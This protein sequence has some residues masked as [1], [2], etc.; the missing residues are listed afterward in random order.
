MLRTAF[1]TINAEE[2]TDSYEEFYQEEDYKAPHFIRKHI[3]VMQSHLLRLDK[4]NKIL[5]DENRQ[6][7]LK[8][9][10]LSQKSQ[11]DVDALRETIRQLLNENQVLKSLPGLL[12]AEG[13]Q[14]REH[15]NMRFAESIAKNNETRDIICSKLEALS[16]LDKIT[17]LLI[18][19]AS[20]YSPTKPTSLLDSKIVKE[21]QLVPKSSE[22]FTTPKQFNQAGS[23]VWKGKSGNY[24]CGRKGLYNCLKTCDGQC[25]PTNGCNC[26][27]CRKLDQAEN[28]R[29]YH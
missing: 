2:D 17:E 15:E 24:Y 16:K 5:I 20:Q 6:V 10:E 14:I 1:L 23:K 18:N 12:K 7:K 3:E 8:L 25:G 22:V 4:Q 21:S 9:Q 29:P 19:L 28:I 11:C 27:D 26:P 13:M